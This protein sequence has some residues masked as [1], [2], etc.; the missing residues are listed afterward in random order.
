MPRALMSLLVVLTVVTG[1]SG[2]AEDKTAQV[3]SD[4]DHHYLHKV[5][6]PHAAQWGYK[7]DLG[8]KH[9]GDLSPNY[10]LAKS[11]HQQSPINIS[12]SESKMMDDIDFLYRPSRIKIVYNGHTV[13]DVQDE[14]SSIVVDGEEF[15]LKQFHFHSPSEHTLNGK[16]TPMEMHLVH[17]SD[18]GRIAVVAV[19]I[20]EGKKENKAFSSVWRHLPSEENKTREYRDLVDTVRMLPKKRPYY[21]YTGSFTT[22]PCTEE[23]LWLVLAKP[24]KLSGRQIS[25]FRGIIDG[26]NRPTQP[27]NGRIVLRQVK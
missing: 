15:H 12:T 20:K 5:E 14:K 9:W 7:G 27:L 13:E 3:K 1:R 18:S 24:S 21:R 23:V 11:G 22:P 19:M 10:V 6:K 16:H 4:D 2:I 17:A 8:P 26:N 25:E